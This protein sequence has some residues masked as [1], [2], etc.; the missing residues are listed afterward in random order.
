M[1]FVTQTLQ[2][3]RSAKMDIGQMLMALSVSTRIARLM[4]QAV[5]LVRVIPESVRN[6]SMVFG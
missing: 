6:V 4:S 3:A 1:I 2:F 5:K